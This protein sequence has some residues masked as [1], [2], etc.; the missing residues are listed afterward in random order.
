MRPRRFQYVIAVVQAREHFYQKAVPG[1]F[2]TRL[3]L[4]P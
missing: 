4:D 1:T 3:K 2:H